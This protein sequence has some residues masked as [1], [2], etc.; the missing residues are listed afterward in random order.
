MQDI[1]STITEYMLNNG[2]VWFIIIACVFVGI[3][4]LLKTQFVKNLLNSFTSK[5][6]KLQQQTSLVIQNVQQLQNQTIQKVVQQNSQFNKFLQNLVLQ[7]LMKIQSHYQKN[8]SQ[9]D[10]DCKQR[11]NIVID[12]IENIIL[13]IQKK[14]SNISSDLDIIQRYNVQTNKNNLITQKTLQKIFLKVDKPYLQTSVALSVVQ[15]YFQSLVCTKL[16]KYIVN[17][18]TNYNSNTTNKLFNDQIN[19][20]M[21]QLLTQFYQKLSVFT[22]SFGNTN[23]C[24]QI[25]LITQQFEQIYKPIKQIIL[26]ADKNDIKKIVYQIDDVLYKFMQVILDYIIYN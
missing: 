17:I 11:S 14:F 24:V 3:Y 5:R 23:K 20:K 8:M 15:N 2:F 7:K 9:H 25:Y 19:K 6:Q 4:F 22:C 1:G 12:S 18:Y 16:A 26:N 13:E 10:N 21:F